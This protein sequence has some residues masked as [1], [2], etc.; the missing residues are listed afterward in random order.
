MG[1]TEVPIAVPFSY[2]K[3]EL[4]KVQNIFDNTKLR[5]AIICG[6]SIG[7]MEEKNYCN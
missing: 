5:Q 7:W 3:K 1:A 2:L 4:S 6:A